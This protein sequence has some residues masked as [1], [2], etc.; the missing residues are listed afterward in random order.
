MTQKPQ[1]QD[2]T[3]VE[4]EL[5]EVSGF[6]AAASVVNSAVAIVQLAFVVDESGSV[7]QTNFLNMMT[8]IRNGLDLYLPIDGSVEVTVIKFSTKSNLVAAP[9]LISSQVQK[10]ALLNAITSATFLGGFTNMDLALDLAVAQLTGSPNFGTG[11]SLINLATDGA[12]TDEFAATNA[13]FNAQLAGISGL[14]AES[15]GAAGPTEYLA[16][17]VFPGTTPGTIV[18]V[19]SGDPVPNPVNQGFVIAV[20]TFSEF[21]AAIDA[22]IQRTI[23]AAVPEPGVMSMLGAGVVVAGAMVRRRNQRRHVNS[24]I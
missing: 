3:T 10:D 23:A 18:N 14:S 6:L 2:G 12:P 9:T 19:S 13:A 15:I 24:R 16:S 22:K 21:D 20:S 1:N 4:W 11:V 7:G 8:G 17:I 5:S